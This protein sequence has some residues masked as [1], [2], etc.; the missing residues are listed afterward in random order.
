MASEMTELY[1]LQVRLNIGPDKTKEIEKLQVLL[2]D[3][4]VA[5]RDYCNRTEMI[6]E[7]KVYARQIAVIAY[8]RQGTEGETSRSEG[9]VSIAYAADI[10]SDIKLSL[11]K[12]R[13]GKVGSFYATKRQ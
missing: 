3:A 7:L 13:K 8:N 9:G 1:K 4:E 11:N 5:V 10:P 12:Y 6:D 2:E